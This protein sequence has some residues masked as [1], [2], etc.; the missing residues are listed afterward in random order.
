[1]LNNGGLPKIIWVASRP[2]IP[3]FSG[4]TSKSLCGITALSA[5]THVDVVS[6]VERESQIESMR[7]FDKF[8][9]GRVAGSHWVAYGAR[10]NCVRAAITGRFQF[11]SRLEKSA[12][13]AMLDKLGWNSPERVLLL[14]DINLAPFVMRYGSNAILSPHDCISKMFWSHFRLSP[15]G[16][17]ATRY[18]FQSLIAR[19]YERAFYHLALLTHVITQ[20]DRVW[21]EA[22]NPHARYEVVPNADLLNPGFSGS[23]PNKWDV[24]IW[25]DL[26]ISS[27]ARGAKAFLALA[28][29][30]RA[31]L[32]G[33]RM[34]VVGR[35]SAQEAQ[36]IL[37]AD[38]ISRV[39]YA[40]KL[41]DDQGN[42]QHAKI[43]VIPDVGGTGT[44]NRC[45]NMLASGKCLACLYP[46]MEGVERACDR[47]AINAVNLSELL[48]RVKHA[49]IK[50]TWQAYARMGQAIFDHRYGESVNRRL[51]VEMIERAVAIRQGSSQPDRILMQYPPKKRR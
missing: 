23:A 49:L 9:Q 34:L 30:D 37:G 3:P 22:I 27:I 21:L 24:L 50:E 25:G 19:R 16:L 33:L 31:W 28:A 47:G 5:V 18:M 7:A 46:Q 26:R 51:W 45:V 4:S 48:A 15:P 12:L 14:D 38:L 41:E 43:T 39:A 6:Y 35:A 10:A 1:M 44:K 8:W 32:A 40:S 42:L 2:P 11:G 13:P 29:Q 36:K 20:R 17:K